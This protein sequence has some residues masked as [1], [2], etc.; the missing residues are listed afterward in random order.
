MPGDIDFDGRVTQAELDNT[1][2]LRNIFPGGWITGDWNGDGVHDISDRIL[3]QSVSLDTTYFCSP[4][5]AAVPEPDVPWIYLAG[6]FSL[7][8]R[9]RRLN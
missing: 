4:V 5:A 6:A 7:L 8:A 2:V 9:R 1:L 3:E